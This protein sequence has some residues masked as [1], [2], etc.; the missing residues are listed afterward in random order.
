MHVVRWAFAIAFAVLSAGLVRADAIP[1]ATPDFF[2]QLTGWDSDETFNVSATST[3]TSTRG[4]TQNEFCASG[5]W[6][7]CICDDPGS[8]LNAGGDA[9][10]FNSN[11]GATITANADGDATVNYINV[12]PNIESVILT[13]T[14][15]GPQ[16]K[17][18]F[19][20]SSDVFQFCGFKVVDPRGSL[21]IETLYTD[22]YHPGGIPTAPAPEPRQSILLLIGL[23]V[24]I[25]A[26]RHSLAAAK[27]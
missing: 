19:T 1:P 27:A 15:S 9:I 26:L 20:C 22:P 8:R 17:N 5:N 23:A 13:T 7:Q 12:G 24:L 11:V 3:D 2:I 4:F 16:E 14:I 18:L 6:E 21:E 25:A 10:D